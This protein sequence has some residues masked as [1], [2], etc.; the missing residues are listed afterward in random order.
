MLLQSCWSSQG[1][2]NLG[3]LFA[4]EPLLKR[5]LSDEESLRAS[6]RRHLE[7]FNTHPYMAGFILG[8]VGAMEEKRAGA[9]EAER[10]K[11]EKRI[12]EVKRAMASGLAAIGDSFFWGNLRPAAA[13]AALLAWALFGA[14]GVPRPFLCAAVL[15]LAALNV[16]ALWARWRGLELGYRH[17]E[18]L[19]EKLEELN[20]QRAARRIRRVGLTAA[21]V[22]TALCVVVPPW[23]GSADP[24]GLVIFAAALALKAFG[25]SGIRIF[26]AAAGLC[27]AA[28]A[29]GI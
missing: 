6:S 27:V 8:A 24:R 12:R 25:V 7:Y 19:P 17:Q 4:I 20:W 18:R 11:I 1:M 13:A 3:F 14:L 9:P 21:G 5:F 26:A 2:Q 22:L 10:P 29:A 28:S 15:Y 16:P 23:G